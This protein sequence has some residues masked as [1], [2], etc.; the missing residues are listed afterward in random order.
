M[1]KGLRLATGDILA[2]LNGDDVYADQTTVSQMAEF[3]QNN[4]LDAGYGDL[5]YVD[6]H[7]SR[8]VRRF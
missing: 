4:S 8:Y 6:H 2:A 1:N 5:T 7:D 3:I